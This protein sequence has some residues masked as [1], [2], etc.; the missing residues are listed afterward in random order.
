MRTL[1]RLA[2]LTLIVTSCA[3]PGAGAAPFDPIPARI[4]RALD[5]DSSARIGAGFS[6]GVWQVAASGTTRTLTRQMLIGD[7]ASTKLGLA[8]DFSADA[9]TL[10]DAY[11][12]RSDSDNPKERADL[13]VLSIELNNAD[14]DGVMSGRVTL[15]SD[16]KIDFWVDMDEGSV[17]EPEIDVPFVM[18]PGFV[19]D[20]S[21]FAVQYIGVVGDSRCPPDVT[22]I[23]AGEITLE[24]SFVDEASRRTITTTGIATPSGPAYG[25]NPTVDLEGSRYLEVLDA[26]D[27]SATVVIR[28]SES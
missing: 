9:V 15:D 16:T 12:L 13:D 25:T 22:C 18:K 1:L 17:V 6:V 21:S 14:P 28:T 24:F 20:G 8:I 2:L 7:E 10:V 26:A 3:E 5:V 27:Q 4:D 19:I 11:Q 23:W